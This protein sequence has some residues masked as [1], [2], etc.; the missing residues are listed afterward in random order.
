MSTR[1]G[2]GSVT[3]AAGV[4]TLAGSAG[5]NCGA[6][7][8]NPFA[9]QRA[10]YQIQAFDSVL[11]FET[12]LYSFTSG[13]QGAGLALYQDSSNAYL[14]QFYA[15]DSRIYVSKVGSNLANTGAVATPSTSPHAYRIYINPTARTL[16]VIE[17]DGTS[18]TING[19]EIQFWYRVGD[20]G[21]WTLLHSRTMEFSINAALAGPF[22]YNGSPWPA[23][24]ALYNYFGA[25]QWDATKQVFIPAKEQIPLTNTVPDPR[26]DVLALEDSASPLAQGGLPAFDS[27]DGYGDPVS[28]REG[29]RL[30]FE[31]DHAI[32]SQSGQPIHGFA[33]MPS[34][35][36]QG[37]SLADTPLGFEDAMAYLLS[38]DPE[39]STITQDSDLH[40]HFVYNK[41]YLAVYYDTT[42]DPWNTPTL[43][44]FTGYARNGYKYTNGVQDAGPVSAPWRSE[45]SGAN[46]SSRADFPLKVLI[47]VTLRE[48][49]IFDL[50][51]FTGTPASLRVWMRFLLGNDVTNFWALGRGVESI[52]SAAFS[53]GLLVVGTKSTGWEGGGL[54]TID[55][56]ATTTAATFSLMRSDGQWIGAGVKT[57]VDRNTTSC[58]AS[59]GSYRINPED[60]HSVAVLQESTNTHYVALSG[61]DSSPQLVKLLGNVVQSVAYAAGDDIGSDNAGNYRQVLFDDVGWLWFSVGSVLYRNCRDWREGYMLPDKAD[62]RQ[63]LIDLGVPIT[64]LAYAKDSIYAGTANG[65]YR[66]HKGSMQAYL[67]YTAVGGGGRGR[68]NVAGSGEKLVGESSAIQSLRAY[69]LLLGTTVIPYLS[70]GTPYTGAVSGGYTLIRLWDDVVVQSYVAPTIIDPGT[71]ISPA[72]LA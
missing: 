56:K 14:I 32:L 39:F 62:K 48:L 19:N 58:Y 36:D 11:K 27:P 15:G 28:L 34:G 67:A 47:V 21:T 3:E 7:A 23:I 37:Y 24:S 59:S 53:N 17:S 72:M 1:P 57:I 20:A 52:R 13:V 35:R 43:N 41:P 71:Y 60:V 40:Y 54:H 63:G 18:F 4:L 10:N 55:F 46:R 50:D 64:H 16:F 69:T 22:A 42:L 68:L 26:Q 25:Y 61:E 31:D 38:S 8:N 29:P 65:I 70:V 49:V 6:W 66:I 30:G 2:N 45:A 5:I 44:N 9:Y 33:G 51:T 12:R